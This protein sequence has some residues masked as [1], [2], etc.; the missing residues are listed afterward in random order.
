MTFTHGSIHSIGGRDF[1]RRTMK[2]LYLNPLVSND[3]N[4]LYGA[5]LHAH[6]FIKA[7]RELGH[8]I[9]VY[10]LF[11]VRTLSK[12]I[13]LLIGMVNSLFPRVE[14]VSKYFGGAILYYLNYR[15]F[16]TLLMN[17]DIVLCRTSILN[18]YLLK[19]L[20][21]KKV[22]YL[23]E[24]NGL[25]FEEKQSDLSSVSLKRL[26][27][28][29]LLVLRSSC[30]NIVV[31]LKLKQTLIN[32]GL[33][34]K[35]ITFV[36]NGVDPERFSPS[37]NPSLVR[38]VHKIPR[39]CMVIGFLGNVKWVTDLDT[40]VYAV[41]KLIKKKR[42]IHLLL[43]GKGTDNRG[44]KDLILSE[45]IYENVSQVG[46]IPY[47][48]A[49][50]YLA[51]MDILVSSFYKGYEYVLPIKEFT[52]MSMHKPIIA[53]RRG[54]NFD[55]IQDRKTGLLVEPENEKQ[56]TDGISYLI[57]HQVEANAM[58]KAARQEI[59]SNYTWKHNAERVINACRAVIN[60]K[61]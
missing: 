43:A 52:Y 46:L 11:E 35:K 53:T 29:E 13:N 34:E 45:G 26:K 23:T 40:L 8:D 5:M 27:R 32:Y 9:N 58:G 12:I 33:K 25:L 44:I 39:D 42:K 19:Q 4:H 57:D 17:N 38:K 41:S 24:I 6:E 22:P 49:P 14:Y 51:A 47:D 21:S 50:L 55:V 56:M 61:T 59:L 28:D 2:I 36:P 48:Q 3:P 16:K 18:S 37:I 31:S 54:Q 20:A 30:M 7:V 60:E 1:N 10:P 15:T